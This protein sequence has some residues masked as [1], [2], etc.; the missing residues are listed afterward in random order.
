AIYGPVLK[1]QDTMEAFESTAVLSGLRDLVLSGTAPGFP[2]VSNTAY[3]D[4]N[5]NFSVPKMIQ[6]IVVDG[7]TIDD[8]MA[9]AQTQGEAI[10]AKYV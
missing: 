9:E 4:F 6:R 3:A 10:Y 8:A 2:D 5:S 1:S 7:V